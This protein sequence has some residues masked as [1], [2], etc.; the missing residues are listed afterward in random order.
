MLSRIL[1]IGILAWITIIAANGQQTPIYSQYMFN[2]FLINPAAAGSE[3]LTTVNLTSREQWLGIPNSPTTNS[4]SIQTRVLKNSFI[5]KALSLRKKFSKRSRSGRVGLGAY[6]YNDHFGGIN[7][8]GMQGTYGYHIQMRQSQ[9]SFGL[10]MMGQFMNIDRNVIQYLQST[11]DLLVMNNNLNKFFVDANF[12]AQFTTPFLTSGFSVTDLAQS[13]LTL[14]E[15]GSKVDQTLR[16]YNLIGAYKFEINRFIM[17]EPS[18][19]IKFTKDAFQMDLSSRVYYKEDYWTGLSYRTGQG[20]A[21]IFM[22]GMRVNKLYFG[23]AFDYTLNDI[24]AYTLGSHEFMISMKFGENARRYR[25][26]NR[27]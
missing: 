5:A 14:T 8:T 21:I 2:T 6:I 10:T 9:L 17:I 27:Y 18:T 11:G 12:G 3:G 24:Q 7:R 22:L 19:W 15:N 25:W 23:Y 16:T 1:K 4:I 13:S 26:L 20:G